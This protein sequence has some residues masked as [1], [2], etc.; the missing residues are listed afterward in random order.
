MK[1]QILVSTMF[2]KDYSLLDKLNIQSDAIII[3]Q[4]DHY[5]YD[6]FNYNGYCVEWFTVNEKGLS[7]SRNLALSRATGDICVLV[8]DDEQLRSGYPDIIKNAFQLNPTA[9]LIAF[10]I[11]SIGNISN[12]YVN[13]KNKR[14]YKFNSMRYGSARLAFQREKIIKEQIIFAPLFGA[15]SFFSSGEDSIFLTSCF[16]SGLSI[17]ASPGIIADIHDEVG[18]SS[19]FNGYNKKYFI[20]KGAVYAAMTRYLAI[21]YCLYFALRHKEKYSD[22]VSF[23]QSMKWMLQGIA[24]YR[25][26]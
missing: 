20:D 1:V 18:T 4:D 3:N 10:N 23:N 25:S 12:R 5:A 26:I 24:K 8:D 6:I 19:W 11:A 9:D 15:G 22:T 16:D 21:G 7:R 14:L 2:Q 17:F 13:K